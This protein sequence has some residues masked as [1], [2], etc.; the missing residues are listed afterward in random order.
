MTAFLENVMCNTGEGERSEK[1][2]ER[3]KGKGDY[4][5]VAGKGEQICPL[6][7]EHFPRKENT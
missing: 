3:K 5:R 2:K 7:S 1:K 6:H 4:L